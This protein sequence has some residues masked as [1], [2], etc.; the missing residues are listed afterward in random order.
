LAVK[1]QTGHNPKTS[2]G[3]VAD[4]TDIIALLRE[5]GE[6]RADSLVS[7]QLVE[8]VTWPDVLF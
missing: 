4:H 2:N 8:R 3:R 5:S 1:R 6:E 7:N